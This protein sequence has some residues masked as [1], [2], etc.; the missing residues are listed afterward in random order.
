[1][2]AQGIEKFTGP[3]ADQGAVALVLRPPETDELLDLRIVEWG[4]VESLGNR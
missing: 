2:A 4:D 1:M 3:L